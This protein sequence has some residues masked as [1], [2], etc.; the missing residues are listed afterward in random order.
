MK[1]NLLFLK[2]E[3]VAACIVCVSVCVYTVALVKQEDKTFFKLHKTFLRDTV[4]LE[5]TALNNMILLPQH[6]S[7][8]VQCESLK[9]LP[10]ISVELKMF[11]S[12]VPELNEP[13][14]SLSR[15]FVFELNE[16][17][18]FVRHV[19]QSHRPWF[20]RCSLAKRARAAELLPCSC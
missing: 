17:T 15:V 13:G 7:G 5:T 2:L 10:R 14:F 19:V 4:R 1:T 6:Y 12:W 11:S 8:K 20:F 3:V 16:S 9:T 18:L